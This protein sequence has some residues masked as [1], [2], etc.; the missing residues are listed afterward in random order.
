MEKVLG[1]LHYLIVIIIHSFVGSSLMWMVAAKMDDD[2]FTTTL[3]MV[4]FVF[5]FG[6]FMF[7]D[8]FEYL[9]SRRY[10]PNSYEDATLVEVLLFFA[11][12][13]IVGPVLSFYIW[14]Y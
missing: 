11:C 6:G 13:W 7:D 5:T 9:D 14:I 8:I 10:Y 12:L 3:F 4:L 2:I 1:K